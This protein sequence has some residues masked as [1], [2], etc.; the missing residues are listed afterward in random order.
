MG[1]LHEKILCFALFQDDWKT[2]IR[3]SVCFIDQHK[4]EMINTGQSR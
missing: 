2:S 1:E 4:F 3:N